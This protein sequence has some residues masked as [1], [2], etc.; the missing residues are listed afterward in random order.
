MKPINYSLAG[1]AFL[2]ITTMPASTRS[3][4]AA[5]AVY[6]KSH[7]W[8]NSLYGTSSLNS[9]PFKESARKVQFMVPFPWCNDFSGRDDE[10]KKLNDLSAS[11][12]NT[13]E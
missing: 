13:A 9:E 10:L 4:V 1:W 7:A 8:S 11:L 6:Y 2:E 5:V 12:G 3:S